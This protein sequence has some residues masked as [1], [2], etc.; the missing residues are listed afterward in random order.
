MN[1]GMNVEELL[2]KVRT[3]ES[4]LAK[5]TE[6]IEV[7]EAGSPRRRSG[8]IPSGSSASA[9]LSAPSWV[10]QYE[11]AE[12]D[13][14]ETWIE[15]HE[16][17]ARRT[18]HRVIVE[19][20]RAEGPITEELALRRVREAWGMRRAGARIQGVFDQ[21]LRQLVSLSQIHRKSGVLA[22]PGTEDQV[23]PV[24]I[25]SD[26]E[27]SRRAVDEIPSA[28]LQRAL[29]LAAADLGS[30]TSDELTSAV[31]K[32]F[33]WTRRGTEIQNTLDANLAKLI[34]SGRL[35]MDGDRVRTG[36]HTA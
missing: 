11:V 18:L 4:Q 5:L 32:L 16:P 12:L 33:G 26:D 9:V 28:E 25:P 29:E 31:A 6:R 8:G 34:E 23:V 24:R 20:V 2:G 3:L 30:P 1:D 10:S 36:A 15:M 17:S 22:V 27:A 13:V 7:L 14:G 35:A 19:T 21:A